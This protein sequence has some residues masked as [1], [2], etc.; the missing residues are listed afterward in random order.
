VYIAS[1][2]V[3]FKL[4]EYNSS[5]IALRS[6]IDFS[7]VFILYHNLIDPTAIS[8]NCV[9]GHLETLQTVARMNVLCVVRAQFPYQIMP[10]TLGLRDNEIKLVDSSI[11]RSFA[12]RLSSAASADDGTADRIAIEIVMHSPCTGKWYVLGPA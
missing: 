2:G 4:L 1:V 10:L 9:I 5:C 6:R 12:H 7:S 8:C 11:V 3:T